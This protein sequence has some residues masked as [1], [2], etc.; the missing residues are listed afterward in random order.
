M[1]STS[2]G[3]MPRHFK[4][5]GKEILWSHFKDAYMYDIKNNTIQTFKY[6]TT[7]HFDPGSAE[8]MRNYLANDALSSQMVKVLKVFHNI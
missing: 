1:K 4:L 7:Q 2:T 3:K 8:K 5:D 6:L